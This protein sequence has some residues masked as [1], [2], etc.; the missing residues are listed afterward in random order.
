MSDISSAKKFIRIDRLGGGFGTS[1]ALVWQPKRDSQ[2]EKLRIAKR[3]MEL[4]KQSH[5]HSRFEPKTA[6]PIVL[7]IKNKGG[8]ILLRPKTGKDLNELNSIWMTSNPK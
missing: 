2:L 8:K 6:K 1:K 3:Q 4:I 7:N 5:E